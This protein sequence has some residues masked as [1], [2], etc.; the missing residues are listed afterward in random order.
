MIEDWMP[1]ITNWIIAEDDDF[2]D[3]PLNSYFYDNGFES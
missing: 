1:F 3:Y 2:E